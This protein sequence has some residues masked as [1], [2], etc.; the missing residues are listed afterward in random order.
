MQAV[1]WSFTV[2]SNQFQQVGAIGW[3]NRMAGTVPRLLQASMSK[4]AREL[5]FPP[6]TDQCCSDFQLGLRNIKTDVQVR[7]G[8]FRACLDCR[9]GS[10]KICDSYQTLNGPKGS[11]VCVDGQLS[12]PVSWPHNTE[13]GSRTISS[14]ESSYWRT[15]TAFTARSPCFQHGCHTPCCACCG[16]ATGPCA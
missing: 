11:R 4:G 5:L 13:A 10:W 15:W 3:Q 8:R 2:H 16:C 6:W 9:A 1:L 14:A 12:H 7:C